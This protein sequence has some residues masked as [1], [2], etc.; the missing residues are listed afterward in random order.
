MKTIDNTRD[1]LAFGGSADLNAHQNRSREGYVESALVSDRW[2]RLGFDPVVS[3]TD[4]DPSEQL[5]KCYQAGDWVE[6]SPADP[7]HHPK[8]EAG[9]EGGTVP[10]SEYETVLSSLRSKVVN[11][12]RWADITPADLVSDP[13]YSGSDAP[14]EHFPEA[15]DRRE[16]LRELQ[17]GYERPILQQAT[18]EQTDAP[19]D[20]MAVLVSKDGAT[21]DQLEART[22]LARRTIQYHVRRFEELG[23]VERIGNPV[24]VVFDLLSV[25]ELASE[26]M[27]QIHPGETT[28]DR[29]GEV[30]ERAEERRTEREEREARSADERGS[31]TDADPGA[32]SK[33]DGEQ[34]RIWRYFEDMGITPDGLATRLDRGDLSGRDVRIRSERPPDP[35]P[36]TATAD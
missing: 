19:H 33:A 5:L 30:R 7:M 10:L 15:G 22:G 24:V 18:R 21:Y 3:D 20:I 4:A 36:S 29:L 35:S 16:N 23:F 25:L 9:L 28:A 6:R 27:D 31:G 14:S 34:Q 13:F 32:D 1:V 12:T 17:Q 2:D 11:H 8:L 26:V